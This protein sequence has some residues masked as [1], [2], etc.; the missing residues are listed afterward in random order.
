MKL[1]RRELRTGTSLEKAIIPPDALAKKRRE[2]AWL[3]YIFRPT[4][5]A[6]VPTATRTDRSTSQICDVGV[7]WQVSVSL[8]LVRSTT[9]S[10]TH[11]SRYDQATALL[12]AN[13]HSPRTP[14][15]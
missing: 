7:G 2:P 4:G 10:G 1:R 5:D 15:R 3:K 14:V 6:P 9:A 11:S 13:T 8:A 12:L